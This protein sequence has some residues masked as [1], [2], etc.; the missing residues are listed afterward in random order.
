MIH[1]PHPM[2]SSILYVHVSEM[3][4][5]FQR[6]CARVRDVVQVSQ[7]L[8]TF[9]RRCARFT[10][11][12]ITFWGDQ[13]FLPMYIYIYIYTRMYVMYV[14]W[15]DV[16]WCDVMWCDVMWCDVMW[17]DVMW[18]DVMWCDVCMYLYIHIYNTIQPAKN[19]RSKKECT[20]CSEARL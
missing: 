1:R 20:A 16:M 18:C 5:T 2:F 6:C 9:H 15:C 19:R 13:H 17:C 11:P 8:C 10:S 12:L 7:Q 14:M 3:L 4:C